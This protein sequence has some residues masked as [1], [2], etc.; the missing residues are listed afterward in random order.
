MP[1][2]ITIKGADPG[3][4]TNSALAHNE[5]DAELFNELELYID[6]AL[7]KI[8][9]LLDFARS[10][11]T[12]IQFK[13]SEDDTSTSA[14]GPVAITVAVTTGNGE[15]EPFTN[16]VDAT[17][18]IVSDGTVG[19]TATIDGGTIPVTKAFSNG[20]FTITLDAASLG[21]VTLGIVGP[22]V[23]GLD[24]SDSHIHTYA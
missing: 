21:D 22:H 14:P 24:T 6:D 2:T 18:E 16:V 20:Q 17:V 15:I 13:T 7:G 5:L 8:N 3:T 11:D 12:S 4:H 9:S 10:M 23:S 19:S 1:F